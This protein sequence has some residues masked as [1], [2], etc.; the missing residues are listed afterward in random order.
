M[1]GS[2]F[3]ESCPKCGGE[4][5]CYT[6]RTVWNSGE[7]LECGYEYHTEE[8]QLTLEEVNDKRE[9]YELPP[10]AELRKVVI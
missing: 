1:A 3:T 9:D 6:E 5:E 2:G 7:C 4:M 10:L 8:G